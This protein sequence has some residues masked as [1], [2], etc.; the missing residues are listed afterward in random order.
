MELAALI[1]ALL[2]AKRLRDCM[3]VFDPSS[4]RS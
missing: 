1:Q 4:N 3:G 2:L